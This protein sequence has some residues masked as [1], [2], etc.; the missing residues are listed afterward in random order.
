MGRRPT[1]IHLTTTDISQALLLQ[2]QLERFLD[3]GYDVIAMSAPGPY[4]EGLARAGIRHEPV[5][6]FTRRMA[7]Q[8]DLFALRELRSAF[9]RLQPDIVHTHTPKP[10]VLGRIAA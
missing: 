6:H 9:H 4:V 7:P 8:H 1:L 5:R 2:P 3:A 10:G